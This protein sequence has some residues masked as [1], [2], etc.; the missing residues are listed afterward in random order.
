[1]AGA[2][3]DVAIYGGS[4]LLPDRYPGLVTSLEADAQ[5][6]PCQEQVVVIVFVWAVAKIGKT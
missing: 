5:A 1:M 3:A 6:S 4:G 2:H